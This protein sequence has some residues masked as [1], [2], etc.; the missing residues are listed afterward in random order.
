MKCYRFDEQSGESRTDFGSVN[1][2]INPLV[3][4]NG[5]FMVVAIHL[6]VG[7]KVAYH[8][9]VKNQLF[10]I[11]QGTGYVPGAEPDLGRAIHA[12]Q[13]AFWAGGEWHETT[14]D[15]GLMAI[16]IE[17]DELDPSPWMEELS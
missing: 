16:V 8:Q 13:G 14:T 9:A 1:F 11:V 10:L 15:D 7:G 6:G 2:I 4:S 5:E 17:G 3:R 12:G